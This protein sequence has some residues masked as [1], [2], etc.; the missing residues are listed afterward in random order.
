MI[1]TQFLN[2]HVG[3][4]IDFIFMHLFR[5]SILYV[6]CISLDHLIHFTTVLLAFVVLDIIS[7]VPS[8]DVS[9]K[10]ISEMTCRCLLYS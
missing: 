4:G 6:S 2:L 8:Q 5:F 1:H 10:N 3:L 9:G 7:L